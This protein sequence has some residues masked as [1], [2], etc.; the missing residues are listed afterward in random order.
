[1]LYPGAQWRPLG[2]QTEPLLTRH[3]IV[4]LHTMV[5]SLAGT[6]TY[7]HQDGYGGT[8]SHF[9]VGH[10]GTVYQ[11]QDTNRQA[12]ANLDGNDRVIS[13]ETADRGPGFSDWSGSNVPAWLPAQLEA[14]AQIVAWACKT[15]DI[16]CALIPDSGKSRRG[17]GYH[18]QGI[19]PWRCSTCERWSASNGKVCPGDRR[20]AQIPQVIERARAIM[21]GEDMATAK[22][23]WDFNVRSLVDGMDRDASTLLQ[24]THSNSATARDNTRAIIAEQN[25]AR[26]RDEAIL[27]AIQGVDSA[28]VLARIDELAV[29]ESARDSN[30]LEVVRQLISAPAGASAEMIVRKI[31]ELLSAPT[32]TAP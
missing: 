9:G 13:I 25:A 30:L 21:S 23:V 7:F 18:R 32:E 2:E 27:A 20:I 28:A 8:E 17:V 22:E 16:P 5:G 26:L 10:D 15:Y 4:C 6:D 19:D 14:I 31:G 29:A 11:W 24:Y 3:D 12:D 1:M